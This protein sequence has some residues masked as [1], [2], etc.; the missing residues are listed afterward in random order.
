MKIKAK[1]NSEFYNTL[2]GSI[3]LTNYI[4]SGCKYSVPHLNKL[5]KDY[6]KQNREFKDLNDILKA[7]DMEDHMVGKSAIIKDEYCPL[8]FPYI[9]GNVLPLSKDYSRIYSKYLDGEAEVVVIT[10]LN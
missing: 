2:I 10:P 4:L 5:M 8:C 1:F 9:D 6:I 3:V 7:F